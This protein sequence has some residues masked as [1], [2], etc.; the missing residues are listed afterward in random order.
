LQVGVDGKDLQR[1]LKKQIEQNESEYQASLKNPAIIRLGDL[2]YR[3]TWTD[4]SEE[5]QQKEL[6]Q[7]LDRVDNSQN[8][9]VMLLSPTPSKPMIDYHGCQM[10][11]ARLH[12]TTSTVSLGYEKSSG[13]AVAVKIVKCTRAQYGDLGRDIDI[14]QRLDHVSCFL[15]YYRVILADTPCRET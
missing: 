14:L 3:L 5:H 6:Q 12:G 7:A 15:R 4:L 11:D 9:S 10:F 2:T 1:D 13:K 8:K